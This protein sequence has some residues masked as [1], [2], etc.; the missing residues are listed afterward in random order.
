MEDALQ[1]SRLVR[2][3]GISALAIDTAPVYQCAAEPPTQ[4][5]GQAMNARYVKL[6]QANAA[7][8]SQAVRAAAPAS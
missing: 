1:A 5:L 7:A 8:V 4:R 6:P 3:A 2:A